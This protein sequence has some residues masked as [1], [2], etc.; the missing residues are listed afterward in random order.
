MSLEFSE[1]SQVPAC[2]YT[3]TYNLTIAEAPS[4]GEPIDFEDLTLGARPDPPIATYWPELNK[5]NFFTSHTGYML[6][7]FTV[8]VTGHPEIDPDL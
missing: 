6:K 8:F 3:M 4:S 2:N 5:I 1:F 7:T